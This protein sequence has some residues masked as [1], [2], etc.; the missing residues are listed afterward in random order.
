MNEQKRMAAERAEARLTRIEFN[1]REYEFNHG[2]K[3]RG[4]GG[5]AFVDAQFAKRNDYLDFVFWAP[6]GLTFTEAKRVAADHFRK[7]AGF[8]GEVVVCS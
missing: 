8:S 4:R 7:T 3:P 5:W 6:G 1:T 2:A